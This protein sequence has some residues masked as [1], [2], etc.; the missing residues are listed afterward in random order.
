LVLRLGKKNPVKNPDLKEASPKYLGP[1]FLP[2][3][4]AEEGEAW[5]EL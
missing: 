4:S 2:D 5:K 1:F 3:P